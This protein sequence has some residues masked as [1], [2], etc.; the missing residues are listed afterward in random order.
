MTI[1][2][3]PTVPECSLLW[4]WVN[5]LSYTTIKVTPLQFAEIIHVF[6]VYIHFKDIMTRHYEPHPVLIEVSLIA[7]HFFL[8]SI[9]RIK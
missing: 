1:S 3:F 9:H 4:T 8:Y 6:C 2:T 7:T 5:M